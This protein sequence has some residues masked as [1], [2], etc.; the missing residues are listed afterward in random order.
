MQSGQGE[1]MGDNG[2]TI[3]RLPSYVIN[4]VIRKPMLFAIELV[5]R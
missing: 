4:D 2:I 5:N 3:H 1:V